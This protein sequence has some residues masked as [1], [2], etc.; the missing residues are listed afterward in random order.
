MM[1][2]VFNDSDAVQLRPDFQSPFYALKSLQRLRNLLLRDS[3][4]GG[5][6]CGRCGVPHVVFPGQC[7]LEISPWFALTKYR[8]S[9]ARRPRPDASNL[10]SSFR[11]GI[12]TV[13]L[14]LAKSAG[15][16][17]FYA[18]ARIKGDQITPTRNQVHQSL[19]GSF[20]GVEVLINVRMVKLD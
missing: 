2:E 9:G 20:H 5:Q 8:P 10:P 14:H 19:E 7:K 12:R 13:P 4:S 17:A 3:A 11:I 1:R 18:L 15:N 6:R 16:A